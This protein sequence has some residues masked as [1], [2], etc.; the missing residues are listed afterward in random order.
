VPS[1]ISTWPAVVPLPYI[2]VLFEPAAACVSCCVSAEGCTPADASTLAD[3]V[4]DALAPPLPFPLPLFP[5]PFPAYAPAALVVARR[6][7][8]ATAAA[9]RFMSVPHIP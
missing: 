2:F 3:A 8:V 4:V 7:A 6:T 5:F 1:A 9:S